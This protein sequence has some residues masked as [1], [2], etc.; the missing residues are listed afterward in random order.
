ME[1]GHIME[2]AAIISA[3]VHLITLFV[4]VIFFVV[5][6]AIPRYGQRMRSTSHKVCSM[7]AAA[8][9]LVEVAEQVLT[10]SQ[11]QCQ[12]MKWQQNKRLL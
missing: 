8:V 3:I 5:V 9:M 6:P 1:F 2:K 11:N 12:L 10:Y 4:A 7:M